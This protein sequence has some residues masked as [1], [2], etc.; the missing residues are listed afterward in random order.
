MSNNYLKQVI[1]FNQ[2]S[3]LSLQACYVPAT[4]VK[5]WQHYLI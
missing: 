3:E 5:T 2:E 4:V 1:Y